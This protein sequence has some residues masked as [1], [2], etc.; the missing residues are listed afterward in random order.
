MCHLPP[1]QI[2]TAPPLCLIPS[3]RTLNGLWPTTGHQP[4]FAAPPTYHELQHRVEQLTME[5][6][7]A[8]ERYYALLDRL[9]V[10]NAWRLNPNERE[11][12][13]FLLNLI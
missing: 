4:A 12:E 1:N 2:G 13:K 10:Q 11:R 5:R 3:S 6:D 8:R 7:E 9:A